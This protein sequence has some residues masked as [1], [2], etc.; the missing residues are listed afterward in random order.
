MPNQTLFQIFEPVKYNNLSTATIFLNRE[1][2]SMPLVLR[3]I[4][5]ERII[6]DYS[7][8]SIPFV[9]RWLFGQAQKAQD[10]DEIYQLLTHAAYYMGESF[11]RSTGFLSWGIKDNLPVIEEKTNLIL[12]PIH[13][14]NELFN[15]IMELSQS[16]TW[17]DHNKKPQDEIDNLL[18]NW[19]IGI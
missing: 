16:K 15:Q 17:Q 5:S 14:I 18:I 13:E 6:A 1:P 8:L 19:L 9:L 3:Q 12:S 10:Q 4:R 2:E 7:I 11:V